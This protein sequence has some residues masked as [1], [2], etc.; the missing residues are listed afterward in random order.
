MTPLELLVVALLVVT[1]GLTAWVAVLITPYFAALRNVADFLALIGEGACRAAGWL[2]RVLWRVYL[3]VMVQGARFKFGASKL[4][5]RPGHSTLVGKRAKPYTGLT[6][7]VEEAEEYTANLRREQPADWLDPQTPEPVVTGL[8]SDIS[9]RLAAISRYANQTRL[10]LDMKAA[11]ME[12]TRPLP[13]VDLPGPITQEFRAMV[14]REVWAQ[15]D[16][17]SE[18]S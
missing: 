16:L 8:G 3:A 7:S 14:G 17:L 4:D 1:A 2:G 15:P 11:V 10:R 13:T 18:V 9:A 5:R 12:H 6:A